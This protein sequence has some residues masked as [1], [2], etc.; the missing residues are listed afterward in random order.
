MFDKITEL[1]IEGHWTEA[2]KEYKSFNPSARE[3]MEYLD[4]LEVDSCQPVEIIKDWA[5]LGFYCRD[6]KG[7]QI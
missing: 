4:S 5:L 6:Y 7:G 2:Q 1:I 3:L